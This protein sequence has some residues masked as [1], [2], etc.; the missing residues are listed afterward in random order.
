MNQARSQ[1]PPNFLS[2]SKDPLAAAKEKEGAP[3]DAGAGALFHP[4][5]M[6]IPG[7]MPTTW[8]ER[9]DTT[10]SRNALGEDTV[11]TT[12]L[13]GAGSPEHPPAFPEPMGAFS[14]PRSGLREQGTQQ[15]SGED[16]ECDGSAS[17]VWAATPG[18]LFQEDRQTSLHPLVS[19]SEHGAGTP[20][21]LSL[22]PQR[23]FVAFL[24]QLLSARDKSSVSPTELVLGVGLQQQ[25]GSAQPDG[26]GRPGPPVCVLSHCGHP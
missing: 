16:D 3:E 26:R 20:A 25:P 2:L 23:R 6:E 11:G 17:L 7:T 22:I 14:S 9:Q 24:S 1:Y 10:A 5:G 19:I 15:R 12:H 8:A 4:S 18:M 13:D 21:Q